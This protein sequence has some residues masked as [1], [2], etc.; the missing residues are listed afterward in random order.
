MSRIIAGI[1]AGT[2]ALALPLAAEAG[3]SKK[4]PYKRTAKAVDHTYPAGSA[5]ARQRANSRAYERGEYYEQ[6]SDAHVF[7]S[8]S[9][10]YLKSRELGSDRN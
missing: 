4:K 9:W 6:M 7:G 1:L 3:P 2:V 8:P 5:S 10:W